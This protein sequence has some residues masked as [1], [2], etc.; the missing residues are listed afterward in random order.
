[1]KNLFLLPFA[2]VPSLCLGMPLIGNAQDITQL[3]P[4]TEIK[5]STLRTG[6]QGAEVSELQ[7]ALKLLG[8]YNGSVDGF[9]G[10]STAQ[11]VSQFQQAAGL[12]PDGVTGRETWR[13]LF[14]V[15]PTAASPLPSS[16]NSA[17]SF[18]V[19]STTSTAA[20]SSPNVVK[21]GSNSAA[22]TTSQSTAV[23]LPILRLGMQGPAVVRLQ[24]RL[25]T[26]GFLTGTADGV[27]GPSTQAAV[28]V[29]QQ[30][31]KLPPDGIVGSATWGVL[32]R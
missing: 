17:E 13:R 20:G 15:T 27:F 23:D 5:R 31:F 28:K 14:P 32:L 19:P 12:K 22:S 18:P 25:R 6:S 29:A 26:L 11:A 30:R 8:Y 24:E 21:T 9:Y 3:S 2:L 1:M 16:N 4:A 10:E 7:A